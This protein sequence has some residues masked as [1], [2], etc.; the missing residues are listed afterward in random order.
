MASSDVQ[1]DITDPLG[2]S[3]LHLVDEKL[4]KGGVLGSL[5]ALSW[6]SPLLLLIAALI[7]LLASIH[8]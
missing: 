2:A 5:T 4:V 7:F 1:T 8:L 3:H 6:R